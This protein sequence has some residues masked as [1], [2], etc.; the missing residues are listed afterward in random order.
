MRVR[1]IGCQQA[2]GRGQGSEVRNQR[3]GYYLFKETAA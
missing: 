1:G 3:I 2:G